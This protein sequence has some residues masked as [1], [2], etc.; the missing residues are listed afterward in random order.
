MHVCKYMQ[1]SY[2]VA[3]TFKEI[4]LLQLAANLKQ[5]NL[6]TEIFYFLRLQIFETLYKNYTRSKLKRE[7]GFDGTKVN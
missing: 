3:A 5:S 2:V 4:S 6:W 1:E 7:M